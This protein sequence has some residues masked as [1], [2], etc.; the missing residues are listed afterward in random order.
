MGNLGYT[1]T[2]LGRVEHQLLSRMRL[3]AS[4]H[5]RSVL[6]SLYVR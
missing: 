1:V 2:D 4:W 6:L 3:A 5:I